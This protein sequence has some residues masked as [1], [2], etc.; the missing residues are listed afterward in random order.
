MAYITLALVFFSLSAD[1]LNIQLFRPLGDTYEG[2]HNTGSTPLSRGSIQIGTVFSLSDR[3][4]RFDDSPS[5]VAI[6]DAIDR[7]LTAHNYINLGIAEFLSL[8]VA[9]PLNIASNITPVSGGGFATPDDGLSLGDAYFQALIQLKD[10]QQ[11]RGWGL[12]L[13]P[14]FTVPLN[15]STTGFFNDASY[16][17]GARLALDHWFDQKSYVALNIGG[18]YRFE[19]ETIGSGPKTLSHEALFGLSAVRYLNEKKSTDVF[20]EMWGS[21]PF[22]D[23]FSSQDVSPLE[24]SAG[25]R[26]RILEDTVTL[27][28][29]GGKGLTQSY[30]SPHY[31]IFAGLGLTTRRTTASVAPT[32]T[33][34][35]TVAP[36]PTPQVGQLVVHVR[37]DANHVLKAKISVR[38]LAGE[39]QGEITGPMWK[40]NMAPGEYQVTAEKEGFTS[41]QRLIE[42]RAGKR[43]TD[44]I[45]LEKIIQQGT[46]MEVLGKI[47][48]ASGK[49]TIKPES[50]SI[51][52]NIADILKR[53]PEVSKVRIEAHTDSQGAAALNLKLSKARAASVLQALVE[54]DVAPHRLVSVGLGEAQPIAPNET[55]EGRALNRR[56]EFTILESSD[57][58]VKVKR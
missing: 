10:H 39:L 32:P 14:F 9:V 16:T 58:N 19:E 47:L 41:A 21:T 57:P 23:F 43:F 17:T 56:V 33:P 31:R 50:F 6:S 20:L 54:R 51:V 40:K 36:A 49:A 52:D 11:K 1:A 46:K 5:A 55:E 28:L 22:S 26:Q 25:L 7:F 44:K 2:F 37:D 30:A 24:V 53:H 13:A 3:P 38:N 48:F 29:G 34:V 27:T 4:A 12:A 18:R 15:A 45:V 8:H 35:A 42:L